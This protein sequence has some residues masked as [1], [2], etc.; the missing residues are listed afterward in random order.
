[1]VPISENGSENTSCRMNAARSAGLRRSST[2]M[3]AMR[4]DSSRG[5]VVAD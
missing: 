2:T 3:S 1:M 5:D 4:T